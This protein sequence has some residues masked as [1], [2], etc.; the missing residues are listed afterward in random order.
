VKVRPVFAW[1]DLWIGAYYDRERRHLYLLPLPCIGVCIEFR[2][3]HLAAPGVPDGS[4][5]TE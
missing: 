2:P 4:P 3:R 1:F 5:E